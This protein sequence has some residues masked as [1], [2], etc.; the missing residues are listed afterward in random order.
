[1][2]LW[3]DYMLQCPLL[4]VSPENLQDFPFS[5]FAEELTVWGGYA[6]LQDQVASRYTARILNLG[7]LTPAD[8]LPS[9]TS[10]I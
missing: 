1:M 6:T 4:D 9:S 3:T 2:Y 8:I 10:N 7:N 5:H